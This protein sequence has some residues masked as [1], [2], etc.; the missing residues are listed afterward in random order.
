MLLPSLRVLRLG[1]SRR[2][3]QPA[4]GVTDRRQIP[5]RQ[6]TEQAGRSR[7]SSSCEAALPHWQNWTGPPLFP[8]FSLLLLSFPLPS[9][10]HQMFGLGRKFRIIVKCI[11]FSSS[12][13]FSPGNEV[14]HYISR[15]NDTEKNKNFDRDA[16]NAMIKKYFWLSFKRVEK[17]NYFTSRISF[18]V[19]AVK[20]C[21]QMWTLKADAYW[22][23]CTF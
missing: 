22:T 21:G 16:W 6:M 19:G 4:P 10:P 23:F 8:I 5:K 9:T 18:L 14:S 17:E 11:L 15:E 3:I 2:Y 13:G 1:I 12:R 7:G 20:E